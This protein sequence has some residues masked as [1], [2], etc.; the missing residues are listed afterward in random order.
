MF[1]RSVCRKYFFTPNTVS[2]QLEQEL[3]LSLQMDNL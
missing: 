2:R 1:L 3:G